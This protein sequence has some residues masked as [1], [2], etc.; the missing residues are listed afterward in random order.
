[1]LPLVLPGALAGSLLAFI[2]ALGEFPASIMVYVLS[3]RPISIEILSQ[4]RAFNLG[5]AAAYGVL[6]I[7]LIAV[8]LGI[9]ERL[10]TTRTST[11]L[12]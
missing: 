5:S 8:S 4:V 6:L 3:N 10:R 12:P 11:L 7:L 2:I 9:G 1:V